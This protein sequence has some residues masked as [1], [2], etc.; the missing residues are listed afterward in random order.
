MMFDRVEKLVCKAGNVLVMLEGHRGGSAMPRVSRR[1]CFLTY[2]VLSHPRYCTPTVM[3]SDSP[4][5]SADELEYPF[6]LEAMQS[7]VSVHAR[8]DQVRYLYMYA[9]RCSH[10]LVGGMCGHVFLQAFI[11]I[12]TWVAANNVTHR[13]RSTSYSAPYILT[14]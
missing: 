3:H 11:F 10:G 7:N 5:I 14:R 1:F 9:N 8:D 2:A 4:A 13:T 6:E 12:L